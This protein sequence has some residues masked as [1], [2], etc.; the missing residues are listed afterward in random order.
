[1]YYI[2]LWRA[3]DYAMAAAFAILTTI[4]NEVVQPHCREFD[5]KDATIGHTYI[6][7]TLPMYMF[8]VSVALVCIVYVLGELLSRWR[9]PAGRLNMFL[10]INGWILTQSYSVLF[11]Y[12]IVNLSKVYAGRLR[13]DFLARLHAEGITEENVH[14]LSH[15]ELCRAARTGRMSFPSTLSA[16]TFSGFIPPSLYLLGLFRVYRGGRLWPVGVAM[17][18]LVL[19]C[20]VSISRTCIYRHHFDD[21]IAGAVIGACCAVLS[22]ALCFTTSNTGEL[23]LRDHPVNDRLLTAPLVMDAMN[24]VANT[25]PLECISPR[26]RESEFSRTTN[27]N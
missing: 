1:M 3:A 15:D 9:R 6:S 19:P 13:P 4:I 20:Y 2:R 24:S 18:P 27:A 25:E 23:T 22:V 14:T 12:T 21:I 10:H 8:G 16:I 11:A 17:V 26:M 7:G 5:W